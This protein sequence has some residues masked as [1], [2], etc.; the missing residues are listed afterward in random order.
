M[1]TFPR[2]VSEYAIRGE[3]PRPRCI[4]DPSGELATCDCCPNREAE[5]VKERQNNG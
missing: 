3:W 2:P 4:H 1:N 5:F